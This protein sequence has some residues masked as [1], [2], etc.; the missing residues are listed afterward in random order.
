ME[1]SDAVA[2]LDEALGKLP[3]LRQSHRNSPEHVEF[4]QSTG[5]E[6]ARIFGPESSVSKNFSQISY[7]A[8][9]PVLT[10][11]YP[12]RTIQRAKGAG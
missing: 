9:G 8:S 1:K 4:I 10:S 5:L 2:I 7:A 6:L 11:R 3:A 12:D